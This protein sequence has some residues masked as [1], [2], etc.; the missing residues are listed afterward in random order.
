VG[1]FANSRAADSGHAVS[2][3]PAGRREQLTLILESLAKVTARPSEAFESFL[4][5]ER[6][7]L[8]AGTTLVLIYGRPPES[9]AARVA[10]LKGSGYRVLV[11]VVGEGEDPEMHEG[12]EWMRIR[13]PHDLT[14]AG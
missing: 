13:N 1:L 4:E 7:R 12:I 10:A 3:A 9:V 14:G 5:R 8:T 2:L 11:L 6:G